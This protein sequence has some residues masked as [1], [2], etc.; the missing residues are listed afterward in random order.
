VLSDLD[1]SMDDDE[2]EDQIQDIKV[3]IYRLVSAAYLLC[4]P[5]DLCLLSP[6]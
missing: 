1:D 5:S 2:Y 4:L 6:A 3:S